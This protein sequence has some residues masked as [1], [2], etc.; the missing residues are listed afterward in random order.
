[1]FINKTLYLLGISKD[2]G[3]EY[4]VDKSSNLYVGN[5][6][7][8]VVPKRLKINKKLAMFGLFIYLLPV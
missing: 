7:V 1:M 8:A 4:C 3:S 2:Q 5:F 6:I